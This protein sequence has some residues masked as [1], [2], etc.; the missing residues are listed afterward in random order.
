MV[1]YRWGKQPWTKPRRKHTSCLEVLWLILYTKVTTILMPITK[2]L[3][4]PFVKLSLNKIREDV[5]FWVR[6]ITRLGE[7]SSVVMG[8]STSSHIFSAV[9]SISLWNTTKIYYPSHSLIGCFQSLAIKNIVAMDTFTRGYIYAQISFGWTSSSQTSE[10]QWFENYDHTKTCK[11]MFIKSSIHNHQLN[12][13]K[14][15]F[16]RYVDKQAMVHLC[17]CVLFSNKKKWAIKQQ[18]DMKKPPI[19][20]C[21]MKEASLKRLHTTWCQLYDILEKIKLCKKLLFTD[22]KNNQWFPGTP[23]KGKGWTGWSTGDCLGSENII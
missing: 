3:T 4:L 18:E 14:M 8:Y 13:T 6:H 21:L 10:S 12:A 16:N 20:N 5:P 19:Y 9:Y 2:K 23:K 7:S 15:S 22:S 11:W 17:N 1:C